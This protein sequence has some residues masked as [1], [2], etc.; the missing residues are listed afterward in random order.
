MK[1]LRVKNWE[2]FQHYKDRNPPWIKF[3]R[4]LLDDFT[5]CSLAD[6]TKA[7][8]VLIW[9]LASQSGGRIPEDAKFLGEKIGAKKRPRLDEL[10]RAGFLIPE[11]SASTSASNEIAE[12]EQHDSATLELARSRE[13]RTKAP[14]TAGEAEKSALPGNL[15][16]DTWRTWKA[17]LAAKG[18]GMTPQQEALSLVRL[19]GHADCEIV[20]QNAI[21]A[22]H[23]T[24]EPVGGWT[25]RKNGNLHDKRAATAAAMRTTPKDDHAEPTD[26]T[27]ES[28]RIA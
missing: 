17:H 9:L 1:Y 11:Q 10:I 21:A 23:R 16:A 20:V 4:A 2:E 24:L 26:I 18:K 6:D 5:F 15:T 13:E 19:R 8:L 14:Y 3:H 25:D 7:H 27:A 28:R 12:R 22:G